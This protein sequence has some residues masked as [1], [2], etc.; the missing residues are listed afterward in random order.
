MAK[1]ES[2]LRLGRGVFTEWAPQKT[3]PLSREKDE[4]KLFSA[5]TLSV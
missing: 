3:T 2:L 5:D 1:I 4:A